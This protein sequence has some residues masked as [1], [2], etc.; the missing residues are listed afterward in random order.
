MDVL[1]FLYNRW[2][3][4]VLVLVGLPALLVGFQP[5][6]GSDI[7]TKQQLGERLFSDPLLSGDKTISCASC[8]KPQ[9]GFADTVAFSLGV[10]KQI[11]KRNTPS[12]T[13]LSGRPMLFWDGRAGSLEEQALVP[14]ANP[15]EMDLPIEKAV[16]RLQTSRFYK[17]IFLKVFKEAPNE[18][19]LS[20][21]LAAFQRTLETANSP[22]DRYIDGDDD[23]ISA[24][25]K[26]GRMLFIGKANCNTCHSGE[27]FTADRFKSIGLYNGKDL[28]DE[29]RYA[30][31]RDSSQ[32]GLFKVPGLRNVALTAPY[33]H[34]GMFKTLKEVVEYYNDPDAFI[35]DGKNRDLALDKPLQLSAQEI[36]DLVA[37]L[38]TLTDDRFSK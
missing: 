35:K 1:S 28:H 37:F 8:H 29:G 4:L 21:A 11:G 34:N 10:R 7:T 17:D 6:E 5:D 32:L 25:A 15:E 2:M 14:I 13:N 18:K 31:T 23:A 38:E 27:D 9:F 36:D 24:E 30:I 3:M 16:A 20:M 19:N 26:R 33:M 22:Y 12:V